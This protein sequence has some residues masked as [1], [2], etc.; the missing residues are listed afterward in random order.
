MVNVL[1]SQGRVPY[2]YAAWPESEPRP[3]ENNI[4]NQSSILRGTIGPKITIRSDP[5][6]PL[7]GT[8][9]ETINTNYQQDNFNQ[10]TLNNNGTHS[11]NNS[12]NFDGNFDSSSS[13][14]MMDTTIDNTQNHHEQ[15]RFEE[16]GVL[17]LILGELEGKSP[18]KFKSLFDILR[19]RYSIE[20]RPSAP[21]S[22]SLGFI[23]C[24]ITYSIAS[25]A[26]QLI[27]ALPLVSNSVKSSLLANRHL[28]FLTSSSSS[29][30]LLLLA[31]IFVGFLSRN[32]FMMNPIV[33]RLFSF[34]GLCF[35]IASG[36]GLE[37]L[38][39]A[40]LGTWIAV[41]LV[42]KN[43]LIAR[44]QQPQVVP[45][46]TQPVNWVHERWMPGQWE[47]LLDNGWAAFPQEAQEMLEQAQ[48]HQQP[49]V[50]LKMGQFGEHCYSVDLRSN[51]ATNLSSDEKVEMRVR[52]TTPTN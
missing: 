26:R 15:S 50:V 28:E 24:V 17:D 10:S 14:A 13:R 9:F 21:S 2:P 3:W 39:G 45:K 22:S 34:A 48:Q 44:K 11:F 30:I 20:T 27:A 8:Q 4:K 37:Y 1:H 6:M 23:G 16:R 41:T 40:F 25:L 35:I 5:T 29:S 38:L 52:R 18:R 33:C 12:S 31:G 19:G 47:I 46:E 43:R 36:A 42:F 32:W 49:S 7:V 51:I